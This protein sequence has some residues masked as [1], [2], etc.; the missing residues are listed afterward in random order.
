[1]E[2]T[3]Q[4]IRQKESLV[5][6]NSI[7]K[8]TTPLILCVFFIS[9]SSSRIEKKIIDDFLKK[10]F[11]TNK[12]IHVLVEEAIPKTKA[13][14]Y[15]ENAYNQRN[16]RDGEITFAPNNPPPYKWEID[17]IEILNLKQKYKNDS[18][19]YHWKKSDFIKPKFV[20]LKYKT[21]RLPENQKYNYGMYL[22]RPLIT[23]DKKHA[24]LFFRD[25]SFA[26]GS[27]EKAILLKKTNGHWVEVHHY[28][29]IFEIN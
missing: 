9:C 3:T 29:N 13:L 18:L 14:E 23:S 16:L 25:F 2:V 26:F 8:K 12:Y 21:L 5:Q 27:G 17:S 20:L 4:T 22:S 15:Y 6:N 1:M 24:F 10:E 28:N 7:M 19:I 11:T